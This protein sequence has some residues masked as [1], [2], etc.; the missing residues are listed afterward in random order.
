MS[1]QVTFTQTNNPDKPPITVA[2]GTIDNTTSLQFVGKGLSDGSADG[3][4]FGRHTI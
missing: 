1:Y 2:D 3:N 4:W